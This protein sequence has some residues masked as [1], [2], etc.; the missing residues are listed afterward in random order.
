MAKNLKLYEN[1]RLSDIKLEQVLEAYWNLMTAGEAAEYALVS[2][3]TI[4]NIWSM[5]ILKAYYKDKKIPIELFEQNINSNNKNING[6][7][8]IKYSK[9]RLNVMEKLIMYKMRLDNKEA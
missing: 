9:E 4:R 3:T 6:A 1:R 5:P 7:A 2:I 8:R